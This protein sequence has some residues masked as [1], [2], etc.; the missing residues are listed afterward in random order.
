M[1]GAKTMWRR[2]Y[3]A[4]KQ[5]GAEMIWRQNDGAEMTG[6]EMMAPKS[7]GPKVAAD[8]ANMIS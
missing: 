3:V 6:A 8:D 1:T 5:W 4:P 7:P 2:N